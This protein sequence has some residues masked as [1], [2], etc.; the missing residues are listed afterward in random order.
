MYLL[1]FFFI[2]KF[3]LLKVPG[4]FCR[5]ITMNWVFE[6]RSALMVQD[7]E[8]VSGDIV[9]PRNDARGTIYIWSL[10]VYIFLS[11]VGIVS[12]GP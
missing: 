3:N 10:S 9:D 1:H 7:R 4:G 6:K 12:V 5:V 11:A 2:S 8:S